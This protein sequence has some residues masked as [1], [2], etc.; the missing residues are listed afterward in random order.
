M[1]I[2]INFSLQVIALERFISTRKSVQ[3]HLVACREVNIGRSIFTDPRTP[4]AC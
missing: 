1:Q 3:G 2:E 4:L